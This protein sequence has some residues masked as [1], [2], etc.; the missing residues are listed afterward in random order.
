M[1]TSYPLLFFLLLL[2]NCSEN[3]TW[4]GELNFVNELPKKLDENS[5][6]VSYNTNTIWVIEDNGNE[7]IIYKV[8]FQGKIRKELQVKKAENDDWEDLTK[9]KDGNL[10]IGDFGNNNN[11]RKNLVIYKL[12]NPEKEKGNKIASQKIE[13]HYPEQKKFPPKK[14]GR[15]YDA[16]AFFHY[17]NHLYIFTKDRSKPFNGRS[18]IYRLPDIKGNYEAILVGEITTCSNPDYCQVTSADISPDGKTIIL[19]GYSKL[20]NITNFNLDSISKGD[21][22]EIDLGMG[23]QLESICFINNDTLLLSNE[24]NFKNGGNLY[25]YTLS[26][27]NK[28]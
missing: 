1:K 5:G 19:L 15:F 27:L 23:S 13:F 17:K 4:H 12:P 7:D 11:D 9:D 24:R 25:S 22:E 21:I 3:N 16:E 10:Y 20:W 14:N 8:D 26:K 2:Q 6:I 28:K 18:F